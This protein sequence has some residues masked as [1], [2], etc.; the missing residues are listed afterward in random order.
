MFLGLDTE[1]LI[2]FE[3]IFSKKLQMASYIGMKTLTEFLKF[4]FVVGKCNKIFS[5]VSFFIDTFVFH[6]RV[7]AIKTEGSVTV[8]INEQEANLVAFPET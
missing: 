4:V 7:V 3:E 6:T 2:N 5:F 8:R 1:I